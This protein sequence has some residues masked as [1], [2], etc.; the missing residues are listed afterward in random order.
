MMVRAASRGVGPQVGPTSV[1]TRSTART[2][3]RPGSERRDVY[4]RHADEGQNKPQRLIRFLVEELD[5]A[6][7]LIGAG[8]LAVVRLFGQ[9]E[10]LK[11]PA[12]VALFVAL[13]FRVFRMKYQLYEVHRDLTTRA[14]AVRD[15]VD[16]LQ[17]MLESDR[18]HEGEM[19]DRTSFY[20]HMLDALRDA[21][22]SVDLTQ[23][24]SYPPSHYGTPEMVEYFDLQTRM[25]RER[26]SIKFRRIVAIPT[27]EKLE[28]LLGILDQ[29][30]D[31]PNFQINVIDIS[32]SGG[33]LPPPLSLQIFDRR[34]MCLVDP[35]LGFMLPEDQRHM[36][37]VRGQSV[38]EVFAIYYDS[39]WGLGQ[40]IKEGSIIYWDVLDAI[41]KDLTAR[42]PEK[43]P[44]SKSISAKV[45]VL[46]GRGTRG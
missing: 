34:E 43:K 35:T 40:R 4:G 39:L 11:E 29:V 9:F 3:G 33:S 24:D 18:L 31:C 23:L 32:K 20:R 6:V 45:R 44:L 12:I 41:L 8:A 38:S 10:S 30:K 1:A 27:L 26:P 28:W 13:G 2:P 14:D 25:V 19:C 15:D 36:L 42:Y 21:S 5:A 16:S 22:N 37:W 7:M 46:S 17:S